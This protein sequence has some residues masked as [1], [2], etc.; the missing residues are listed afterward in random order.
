MLLF[1]AILFAPVFVRAYLANNSPH[2]STST[3]SYT[4]K[5]LGGEWTQMTGDITVYVP[6]ARSRTA[7]LTDANAST[8]IAT[9]WGAFPQGTQIILGGKLYTVDDKIGEG[10][11]EVETYAVAF[12]ELQE[13]KRAH[14]DLRLVPD[15]RGE[16]NAIDRANAFG[17]RSATFFVKFP[18]GFHG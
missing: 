15:G 11:D 4:P 13:G 3:F 14:L 7:S 17:R 5:N 2:Y 10:K 18:P 8:G 1:V 16:Q 9:H 12:P 6:A